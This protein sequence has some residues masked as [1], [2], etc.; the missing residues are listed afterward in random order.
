MTEFT[1][2]EKRAIVQSISLAVDESRMNSIL[3]ILLRTLSIHSGDEMAE[4]WDV[5]VSKSEMLTVLSF[6]ASLEK[7]KVFE[8]LMNAI[9]F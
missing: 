5:E 8:S 3:P 9:G 1:K 4:L 2:N 6:N 7:R